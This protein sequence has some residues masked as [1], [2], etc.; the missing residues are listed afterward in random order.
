YDSFDHYVRFGDPT[1]EYGVALSKVAA[2]LMLRLA[3]AQ[4]L[5]LRFSDFSDT[6]DSYV[7]DLHQLVAHTGQ[8]TAHQRRLFEARA[9]ALDSDPTRPLAAPA[10]DS[11]VPAIDL[12]PLDQAAKRLQ[13]SAQ[14]Y[15]AAYAKFAAAGLRLPAAQQGR[16]NQL[17]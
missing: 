16:L 8:A 17:I 6:L 14:A 2:H 12:A 5:P 7:A 4:V 9:Y 3:D 15:E 10:R 1:F 13:Q 11:D